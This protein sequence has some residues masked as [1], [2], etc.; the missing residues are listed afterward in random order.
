MRN[1]H[2]YSIKTDYAYFLTM[3]IVDWVDLFARLNHKML[4]VDSLNYCCEKKG[5]HIF[6]WCLMTN[7]LHLIANTDGKNKLD[8]VV[9]DFKKFTSKKL[10]SQITNE[11][12]SRREW[13]LNKFAYAAKKHP[14]NTDNKV[15]QDGNHAVEIRS[16]RVV[17]QKL[18]YIHKNQVVDRIVENEE[19]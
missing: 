1:G 16:E 9:R 8:N 3:T 10:I 17:W 12:E 19:D 2:H 6:G 15:W 18:N 4:I 5:L 11:P 14:K 13:L 7:H